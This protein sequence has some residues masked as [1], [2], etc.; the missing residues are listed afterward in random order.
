MRIVF[1][2]FDKVK[3]CERTFW[4]KFCNAKL[5]KRELLQILTEEE[6]IFSLREGI[7]VEI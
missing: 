7:I 2:K 6:I 1:D 3:V 4:I 5:T